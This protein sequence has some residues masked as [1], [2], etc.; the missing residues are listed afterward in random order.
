MTRRTGGKPIEAPSRQAEQ[1]RPSSSSGVNSA[2]RPRT[3]GEE[4]YAHGEESN[5]RRVVEASPHAAYQRDMYGSFRYHPH[6][7][8]PEREM[9]S[10]PEGGTYQPRPVSA[11]YTAA[12]SE[13]QGQTYPTSI[14]ARARFRDQQYYGPPRTAGPPVDR[15]VRPPGLSLYP[16]Q[17]PHSLL[18]R[19]TTAPTIASPRR[20]ADPYSQS[21]NMQRHPYPSPAY[22]SGPSIRPSSSGEHMP[23]PRG[24]G[25]P[26]ASR[27]QAPE[28]ARPYPPYADNSVASSPQ[29]HYT[30]GPAEGYLPRIQPT[31]ESRSRPTSSSGG[32]RITLPSLSEMIRRP[33]LDLPSI[34]AST[35]SLRTLLNPEARARVHEDNST[36]DRD[37][38][39]L[40]PAY[41]R[42]HSPARSE[43][44]D[45]QTDEDRR[46]YEIRARQIQYRRPSMTEDA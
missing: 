9:H 23:P 39:T 46:Y 24:F 42:P 14:D 15:H 12:R 41:P 27:M 10:L 21:P 26:A 29:Y 43:D 13:V 19:P 28:S 22:P 1:S 40:D 18:Q 8:L 17:G 45:Q 37:P 11:S 20:L 33:D 36:L 30:H 34:P 35:S 5:K 7:A 44:L 2:K 38:R 16:P 31:S 4:M 3:A 32:Q 25:P 6:A